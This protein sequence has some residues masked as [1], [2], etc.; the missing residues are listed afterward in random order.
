MRLKV[1][2]IFVI[3]LLFY[4]FYTVLGSVD[5][6]DTHP[7]AV[8]SIDTMKFSRDMAREKLS[9]EAFDQVI[10]TQISQIAQL[11]ATHVAV[12]TPYD[13]EFLPFLKRWVASA[14]KYNLKVWFRG[15]FSGWEG[16][17]EYPDINRSTHIRKT[18]A[19]IL[20]NQSLFED[21]DIFTSCP[22]CENG[23]PGDPRNVDPEGFKKFLIQE[24]TISKAAFK[25]IGKNVTANYYSMNGDV[26]NLIMDKKTTAALDGVVTID[27]YVGSPEQLVADIRE[28]ARKS[29]GKVVLG[30]IGVPIPDIHGDMTQ[31]EQA[32]WMASLFAGLYQTPEVVGI[33][34]WVNAGGSTALYDTTGES[35]EVTKAIKNYYTNNSITGRVL[36]ELQSPIAQAKIQTFDM[37]RTTDENG[38][39]SIPYLYEGQK[40]TV[41][42][43]GYAENTLALSGNDDS[44]T[45][46]L[47]SDQ[48]FSRQES[49]SFIERIVEFFRNLFGMVN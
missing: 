27:H 40:V 19:F 33:N 25:K 18:Q 9:D 41:S 30:E 32:E 8:R 2:T 3:C 42:A 34:Y 16:W 7:V 49:P 29:G 5:A 6:A 36:N 20:E 4:L 47:I 38:N 48:T 31:K 15:N 26:A 17:F 10:D 22:E 45:I 46:E 37:E 35:R 1:F 24:Y 43:V 44:V 14:R 39:F 13:E 21:G 11:G 23:G 12:G 28:Y